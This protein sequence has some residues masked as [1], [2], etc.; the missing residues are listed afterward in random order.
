M[1]ELLIYYRKIRQ[2]ERNM[3]HILFIDPLEKLSPK[4][5]STLLMA[6]TLKSLGKEV[7]LLFEK[8]F[9]IVN[10]DELKYQV[11]KFEGEILE[12]FYV[13]NFKVTESL[14]INFDSTT[15]VHM[16]ID[17]P[18]DSRYQ[19]YLWM[20]DFL[21]K[22]GV[23]VTNNPLGIMKY[24]EKLAAYIRPSSIPS[25][26]GVA[27]DRAMNF[28]NFMGNSDFI[29]KP[30]DLFQGIGVKKVKN[31]KNIKKEIE[32]TISEYEG[33]IVIQ[34]FVEEVALGEIRSVFFQGREIGT[35]IKVPKKGEYLA[36]I[37]RGATYQAIKLDPH[38]KA[39]CDEICQEM[40]NDGI[41]LIAFDILKGAISEVNITCP[42]LLVEVSSAE[43][44]NLCLEIFKESDL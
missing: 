6:L 21:Q 3:K 23:S 22:R 33:P 2:T 11:Y 40:L 38:V 4:K 5:D 29:F 16:R 42:G 20:L 10:T 9:Y 27:T 30:L 19:R 43:N 25:F 26:V 28:I 13:E 24:N 15:T 12:N 8:D 32:K 36:N 34:P 35:I 39:E 7:Y 44:R 41:E 31:D 1:N 17:P 14:E 37:A 18:Y